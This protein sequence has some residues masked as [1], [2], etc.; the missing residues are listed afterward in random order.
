M[1]ILCPKMFSTESNAAMGAKEK[2]RYASGEFEELT[3]SY[4]ALAQAVTK[5]GETHKLS[6]TGIIANFA[7]LETRPR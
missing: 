7:M 1:V 2:L 3:S 5:V 6:Q 4:S